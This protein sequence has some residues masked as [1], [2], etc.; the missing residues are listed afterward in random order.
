MIDLLV[1]YPLPIETIKNINNCND[2]GSMQAHFMHSEFL[3]SS[4]NIKYIGTS[5]EWITGKSVH[6]DNDLKILCDQS[7]F[8]IYDVNHLLLT[9]VKSTKPFRGDSLSRLKK[10]IKGNIYQMADNNDTSHG[11]AYT[12][13][14]YDKCGGIRER[15]PIAGLA[16]ASDIFIPRQSFLDKIFRIHID[17][18]LLGRHD[19]FEAIRLKIK[20][21]KDE[22]VANDRWSDIEIYYHSDNITNIDVIGTYDPKPIPLTKLSH[23]YSTSHI[24]IVSHRETMGQYPLELLSSG[25]T[26]LVGDDSYLPKGVRNQ[27]NFHLLETF[28]FLDY[29]K[30]V[31]ESY[32]EINRKSVD[33][34]SYSNFVKNVLKIIL[35]GDLGK[36][37]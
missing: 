28:D 13:A 37:Y 2:Y 31:N 34:L 33:N 4:A 9:G 26:I 1:V 19:A 7:G 3:K 27:V 32:L 17:H 18:R 15:S 21:L 24:G 16:V 20:K 10:M 36:S 8:S 23:I 29:M 5:Y 25:A 11:L 30:N 12:I 6:K 14:H 22:F 35:E